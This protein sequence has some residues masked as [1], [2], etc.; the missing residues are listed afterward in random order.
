MSKA[1]GLAI[2]AFGPLLVAGVLVPFRDDLASANVVLVFVPFVTGAARRA[3]SAGLATP[4]RPAE[5]EPAAGDTVGPWLSASH[6]R[7]SGT[8]SS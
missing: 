8:S 6:A 7:G 2:A 5:P 4:G 1:F 3:S